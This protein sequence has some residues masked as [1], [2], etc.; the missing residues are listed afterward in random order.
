MGDLVKSAREI[1]CPA[2]C[3]SMTIC[4]CAMAADMADRIEALEVQLA[5]ADDMSRAIADNA[6]RTDAEKSALAA[7]RKARGGET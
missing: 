2:G 1:E 6:W 4:V 5:A 7:Y 3:G